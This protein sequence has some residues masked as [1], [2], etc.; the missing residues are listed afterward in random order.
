MLV[1]ST[2]DPGLD[3]STDV[4]LFTLVSAL[5][6]VVGTAARV[7]AQAQARLAVEERLTADER[8]RRLLLEERARIA[9]E[10]HDIVA[11]HMS[12]IAVQASTAEY[13]IGGL[14]PAVKEEFDAI[15]QAARESMTEMRRLLRVLRNEQDDTPR[16]PQPGLADLVSLADATER[17][18]TP[19]TLTVEDLPDE[20]AELVGLTAYRVV[21]EALSNV[22]RHG[23]GAPTTVGVRA[24]DTC[25]TVSVVNAAPPGPATLLEEP[26]AGH[27][28]TGMRERVAL[29]GGTL[30]FGP[31]AG[32]GFGVE[33]ALPLHPDPAAPADP[34][35]DSK[36]GA[37][38]ERRGTG[39]PDPAPAPGRGRG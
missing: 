19:V 4:T 17:A 7:R 12:M 16:A 1:A 30:R 20:V 10:M 18:G 34:R 36:R 38:N 32:D 5:A 11:H 23:A 26:R 14:T 33:A 2:G 39:A 3:T 15:G 31:A 27:G 28:L 8:S 25:L 37:T 29:V 35:G 24:D 6:L 9:R 21:Q 22:V 13:R